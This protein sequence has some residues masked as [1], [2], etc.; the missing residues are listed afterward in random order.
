MMLYD[1]VLNW[2]KLLSIIHMGLSYK[3]VPPVDSVQLVNITRISLWFIG[4]ISN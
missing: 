2:D 1:D 3:V 4:D